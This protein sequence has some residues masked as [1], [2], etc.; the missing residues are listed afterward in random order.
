MGRSKERVMADQKPPAELVAEASSEDT[1]DF[2]RRVKRRTIVDGGRFN[3]RIA[4]S[5][6]GSSLG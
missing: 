5:E 6:D 3:Q 4:S 2:V 1:R